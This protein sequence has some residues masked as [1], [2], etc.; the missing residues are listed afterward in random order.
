M[1]AFNHKNFPEAAGLFTRA[2]WRGVAA[3]E[4][5]KYDEA[6]ADFA[7]LDDAVGYFNRGNALMRARKYRQ[8]IDAYEEAV[9]LQPDW[10]EAEEN[11]QLAAYTA[12]YIERSREDSDTGDESELGADGYEFDNENE[13]GRDMV[14]TKQQTLALESAQKW[15]RTVDTETR[16]FLRSRFQLQAAMEGEL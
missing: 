3:Y 13:G 10:Q 8:A 2:D 5:G 4:A 1:R 9:R 6:A 11:L 15:M 12:D 16:D 14:V 7:R